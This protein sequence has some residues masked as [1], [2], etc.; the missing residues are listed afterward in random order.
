MG[1]GAWRVTVHRVAQ[2]Q[3]W[4]KCLSNHA[5]RRAFIWV[6]NRTRNGSCQGMKLHQVTGDS[7]QAFMVHV[8]QV[9]GRSSVTVPVSAI[10]QARL[11]G[12]TVVCLIWSV[13]QSC[14]PSRDLVRACILSFQSCQPCGLWPTS[15]LCPWDP[16][17]KNTGVGCHAL[18]QGI[19]LS[20]G[21]N[22]RLF[23]LLHW[24]AGSLS[25]GTTWQVP[26]S[27]LYNRVGS[28]QHQACT[29][30]NNLIT[31]L[32]LYW[33]QFSKDLCIR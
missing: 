10:T 19:F 17:G 13:F 30:W 20:Q 25:P 29:V 32:N 7:H 23:C 28:R 11:T 15:L 4:L 33:L 2:S 6:K 14:S 21:S 9:T 5:W 27:L 16:P 3:T 8:S 12:S 1:W 22:S 18:L 26:K 31:N 24:Q